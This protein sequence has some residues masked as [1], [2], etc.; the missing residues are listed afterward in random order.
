[1]ERYPGI[2]FQDG[3]TGRRAT[4]RSGPDVWELVPEIRGLTLDDQEQIE[5][6]SSWM[7]IPL[8]YVRDAIAYYAEFRDEINARV[9][10]NDALAREHR[11]RWRAERGLPAE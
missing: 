3:P 10:A 9:E 4:L 5:A 6:V 1:M 2:F 11:A 7:Q 8:R